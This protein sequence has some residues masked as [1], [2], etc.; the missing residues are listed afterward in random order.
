[1]VLVRGPKHYEANRKA[2]A[3]WMASD[4]LPAL[5]AYSARTLINNWRDTGYLSAYDAAVLV[6]RA[7]VSDDADSQGLSKGVLV[8]G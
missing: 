2:I 3:E 1:M 8:K 4:H 5:T 6:L 7:T